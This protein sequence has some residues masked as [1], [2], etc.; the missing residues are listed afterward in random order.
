MVY[1]YSCEER[2]EIQ[3]RS[4]DSDMATIASDDYVSFMPYDTLS[5][6]Y[7]SPDRFEERSGATGSPSVNILCLCYEARNFCGSK[8]P[9]TGEQPCYFHSK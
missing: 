3:L 9:K 5:I 4:S 6:C 1:G 8:Y 2:L 7:S